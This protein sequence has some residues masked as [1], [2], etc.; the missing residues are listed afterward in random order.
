VPDPTK[1]RLRPRILVTGDLPSP[2]DP[3][4]GCRFRTRCPKFAND[5]TDA[6]RVRCVEEPPELVDRGQG[7]PAACHY[8]EVVA[9]V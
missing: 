1:E 6:E 4:S 9:V 2:A 3:P 7:H 8:A 5:L